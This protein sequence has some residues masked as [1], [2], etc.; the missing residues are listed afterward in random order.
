MQICGEAVEQS[1]LAYSDE[2]YISG[3]G[4]CDLDL[5]VKVIVQENVARLP[6]IQ[7][8]VNADHSLV[9]G[10]KELVPA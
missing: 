2:G 3:D 7:V 9:K 4:I 1:I 10:R 5:P 8:V 6:V